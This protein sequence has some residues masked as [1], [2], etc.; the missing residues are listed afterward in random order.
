MSE[1]SCIL[2]YSIQ[3]MHNSLCARFSPSRPIQYGLFMGLQ[4]G[5]P[6][7]MSTAAQIQFL[8]I[9][10]AKRNQRLSKFITSP[11]VAP[12][13]PSSLF[14]RHLPLP[15]N[16]LRVSSLEW[17]LLRWF[18]AGGVALSAARGVGQKVGYILRG[19][20]NGKGQ[21]GYSQAVQRA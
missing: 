8:C 6:G 1:C 21:G 19:R 10:P 11:I 14:C 15:E 5:S 12:P 18:Q 9:W 16:A 2:V 20:G 3:S 7:Q 4:R 13:P 17:S